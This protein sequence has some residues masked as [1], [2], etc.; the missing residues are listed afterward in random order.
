MGK[1]L[2]IKM[3]NSNGRGAVGII[4]HVPLGPR[5]TIRVQRGSLRQPEYVGA[6]RQRGPVHAHQEISVDSAGST[7]RLARIQSLVSRDY[8]EYTDIDRF[9]M[10]TH[11]THYDLT[12]FIINTLAVLAVVIPK[13]P[14]VRSKFPSYSRALSSL[15]MCPLIPRLLSVH[16]VT[17]SHVLG[18]L[19][20]LTNTK[21]R[22]IA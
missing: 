12:Y 19:V 16:H 17:C 6:D 21:Y 7:V 14:S 2:I 4:P 18:L 3:G 10:S 9:L 13:L 15:H 20:T 22:V 5:N 8:W 1:D 11:Y